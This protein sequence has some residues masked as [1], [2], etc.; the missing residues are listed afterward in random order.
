MKKILIVFTIM[1]F[2]IKGMAQTVETSVS[3]SAVDEK[4]TP[5]EAATISLM[6]T[7]DSSIIK[8]AVSNKAGNF[9]FEGIPY[10]N[11]FIRISSVNFNT[12]N[13]A[14]FLISEN[15]TTVLL[16]TLILQPV[17]KHLSAVVVTR[18]EQN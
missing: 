15:N 12:G 5:V 10:G 17:T 7:K 3:G 2:A 13:S 6:R 8:I 4:N 14:I 18:H 1:F 16:N 11:Y 9:T